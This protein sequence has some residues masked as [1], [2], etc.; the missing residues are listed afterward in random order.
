[1]DKFKAILIVN[2]FSDPQVSGKIF[3]IMLRSI[4]DKWPKLHLDWNNKT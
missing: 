1:M 4:F 2:L 3:E